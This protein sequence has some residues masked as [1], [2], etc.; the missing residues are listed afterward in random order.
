MLEVYLV[1]KEGLAKFKGKKYWELLCTQEPHLEK[2]VP[3][4]KMIGVYE[5]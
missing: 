5:Y 3:D 1:L 2:Y 4:L